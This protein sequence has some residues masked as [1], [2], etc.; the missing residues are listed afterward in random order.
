[1]GRTAPQGSVSARR[2]GLAIARL[3]RP[4]IRPRSA[5][6]C[7][8]TRGRLRGDPD[9]NL[10]GEGRAEGRAEHDR[11]ARRGR[12]ALVLWGCRWSLRAR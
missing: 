3:H 10:P 1:V 12:R 8:S 9:G 6:A 2:P 4:A 7:F 11:P 5:G